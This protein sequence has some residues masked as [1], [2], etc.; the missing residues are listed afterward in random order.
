[1]TQSVSRPDIALDLV[2]T[3]VPI[4]L[5]VMPLEAQEVASE[6][7]N[8]ALFPDKIG[9]IR[10]RM[11]NH[12]QQEMNLVLKVEANFPLSWLQL[13]LEEWQEPSRPDELWQ[14][15]AFL[16]E[17]KESLQKTIS[18]QIPEQ[19]FEEQAALQKQEI[20]DLKYQGQIYLATASET[21]P[22][23]LVGYKTVDFYIQP[24]C[25]YIN[26]LPEIYQQSDFLTRLLMIFE[27]TFDPTVQIMEHFWAYLDPLTA[28]KALLPFLAEA[29]AWPMNPAWKLKVQRR[30]IRNAVELYQ[31]R[32]SRRGLALALHLCTGLP[33]DNHHI[34]IVDANDN[35]FTIGQVWLGQ[36]PTLGGG[37]AFHFSVKLRSSN[38]VDSTE[39]DEDLVRSVI[40]QEKPAFCTYE[41]EIIETDDEL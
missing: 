4:T 41:L 16:L 39:I 5:D 17:P 23:Q 2:S 36:E 18:F 15:Q 11:H 31:W 27:Q 28:P 24:L 6:E 21:H 32:G 14:T 25:S 7:T 1:M 12:S 20:L 34:Q 22:E 3:D 13:D 19:F 10:V 35:E 38:E 29:V 26:F 30:L 8:L 9:D 37:R 40:E 33:N